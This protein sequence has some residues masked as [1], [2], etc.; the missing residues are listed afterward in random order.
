MGGETI[1]A[2]QIEVVINE[3]KK[4]QERIHDKIALLNEKLSKILLPEQIQE[5]K[6]PEAPPKSVLLANELSIIADSIN[7]CI[8]RLDILLDRI[9]I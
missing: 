8:E 6:K 2:S 9:D 7:T 1:R 3:L 4:G 5:N